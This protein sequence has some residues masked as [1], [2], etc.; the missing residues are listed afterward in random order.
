MYSHNKPVRCRG[1]ARRL[2]CSGRA[3]AGGPFCP[4]F[5]SSSS[6]SPLAVALCE[7]CAAQ[8]LLSSAPFQAAPAGVCA[9]E[10]SE[11]VRVGMW[12]LSSCWG[13]PPGRPLFP[14]LCVPAAL[15]AFR[16]SA[17]GSRGKIYVLG[18]R[19]VTRV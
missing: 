19:P 10:R 9:G 13:S 2:R 7:V 16:L 4:P 6:P 3:G 12:A 15:W 8:H 11:L 14:L 18:L 1:I 5:S 17:G